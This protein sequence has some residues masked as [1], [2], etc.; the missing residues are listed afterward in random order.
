MQMKV[1]AL[2]NN[3]VTRRV[4]NSLEGTDIE[5]VSKCIIPEAINLLKRERFDLALID[6]YMDNMET[7]YYRILWLCRTPVALVINGTQ[8]DW[9]TLHNLD[10][11]GFIPEQA[12]DV[13][14]VNYFK[15]IAGRTYDKFHKVKIL[16]VVDDDQIQ[17]ALKL[18]FQIYWP[19]AKLKCTQYGED[20]I[21]ITRNESPDVVL[22]DLKLP[23]IS[24]FDVLSAIRSSS[25]VPVIIMTAARN[26][27]DVVRSVSLG[28]N[29]FVV[30]PFS[31]LELMSRI[32]Q[33]VKQD[34]L[35]S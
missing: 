21:N 7:T 9:N 8:D 5:V 24:G 6:G 23:D 19:E 26:Q 1:L 28:A 20:G 14:L 18:S 33:L 11:D 25:Q 3:K 27:D 13:E 29:S 34:T 32:R 10:A 2:G 4:L 12:K 30:K 22:L 16:A 35:A 17:E 31:Q 15:S